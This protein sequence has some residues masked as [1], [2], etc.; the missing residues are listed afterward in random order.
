MLYHSKLLYIFVKYPSVTGI[1][2][3][4]RLIVLESGWSKN[5]I[6][7]S[8]ALQKLNILGVFRPLSPTLTTSKILPEP[9]TMQHDLSFI[10]VQY[11]KS[12]RRLG[13]RYL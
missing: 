11:L 9:Q 1:D 3:E 8:S 2:F 10:L 4:L 12:T 7:E 6:T 13:T 5:M